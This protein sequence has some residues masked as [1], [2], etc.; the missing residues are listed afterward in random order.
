MKLIVLQVGLGSFGKKALEK[1]CELD[2]QVIENT[3]IEFLGAC[4]KNEYSR[5]KALNICNDKNVFPA[6]FSTRKAMFE[7]IAKTRKKYDLVLVYDAS[8]SSDHARHIQECIKLG[9]FCLVESPPY[10]SFSEEKQVMDLIHFVHVSN[11]NNFYNKWLCCQTES[12][13]PVV[14]TVLDLLKKENQKIKSIET[15]RFSSIGLEKS[16]A[17]LFREGVTGGDLLDL[18]P[19]ESYILRFF[20]DNPAKL[21]IF[22]EN[23]KS[24]YLM[25]SNTQDQPSLMNCSGQEIT[26]ANMKENPPASA[27]TKV[28]LKINNTPVTLNS[29]WLGLPKE[30]KEKTES[31]GRQAKHNFI[32]S[33]KTA[34]YLEE[35]V[36]KGIRLLHIK[37]EKSELIGDLTHNALFSRHGKSWTKKKLV[38]TEGD[39]LSRVFSKTV[40]HILGKGKPSTSR[41]ETEHFMHQILLAKKM[42]FLK[43]M[44]S[45]PK[46]EANKTIE[47]IKREINPGN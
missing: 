38:K 21:D 31:I 11:E 45:D 23:A 33:G 36:L 17:P 40:S 18:L 14:L 29:G 28:M 44:Y 27:Q 42:I 1:W 15:C 35:P 3:K 26:R 10:T 30:I 43:K 25:V 2:G 8:S 16:A 46:Y 13:N 5:E 12:E 41:I 9:F 22:L 6:L 34:M 24:D 32:S 47:K 4:D 39:G 7:H 20:T 19:E 37:L